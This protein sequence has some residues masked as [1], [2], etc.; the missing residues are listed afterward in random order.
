MKNFDTTKGYFVEYPSI[1]KE[2]YL[3]IEDEVY[4]HITLNK[5]LTKDDAKYQ[6]NSYNSNAQ[7]FDIEIPINFQLGVNDIYID[8]K[9]DEEFAKEF[10][11][12]KELKFVVK[13]FYGNSSPTKWNYEY[14][15]GMDGKVILKNIY[16]GISIPKQITT[17]VTDTVAKYIQF[18]I[19]ENAY[20][21]NKKKIHS[22]NS[23]EN[24]DK[25]EKKEKWALK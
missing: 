15:I 20:K 18:P 25:I 10:G 4:Y 16:C 2:D 22:I 17:N 5:I 19:N 7:N 3:L 1:V 6:V 24:W 13:F 23:F 12:N 11:K 21:I 14:K 8:K 9:I